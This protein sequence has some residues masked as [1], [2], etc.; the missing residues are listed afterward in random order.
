[1][2]LTARKIVNLSLSIVILLSL[3]NSV[4]FQFADSI[5]DDVIEHAESSEMEKESESKKESEKKGIDDEFFGNLNLGRGTGL[6]KMYSLGNRMHCH[7]STYLDISTPP[8]ELT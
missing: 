2:I 8:P 1:M 6:D 5:M 4:I 3:S 7:S